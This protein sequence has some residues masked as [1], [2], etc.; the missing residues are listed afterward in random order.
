[1][2]TGDTIHPPRTLDEELL[3]AEMPTI[4]TERTD[5]ERIAAID[6]ELARG[7]SALAGIGCGVTI[8]GSARLPEDDP[9]YRFAR[10]AARLLGEA[11]FS[12]ITGG[13]PGIMEA[14]N[15]GARDAGAISV[16]LN[17]E[18]PHEQAPNPYQDIALTFEHFFT[19]KVMFVRYATGLVV[20]PGGYGTLDE[21]FEA[22]NLIITAK[23][24]HFPVV[25]AGSGHW[26]G[27]VDWM[28]SRIVG[29][30]MLRPQELALMHLIDDPREIVELMLHGAR[31]QGRVD[32]LAPG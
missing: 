21:V 29:E 8:F 12:I 18:L 32:Q 1:M 30:G 19:R 16:G 20:F 22:L 3:G 9:T 7:F 4:A 24:S 2:T 31:R 6:A 23:I 10:E 26:S 11:G 28:H 13:G 27:L 15:R 5:P 17:I 25:L 14:G